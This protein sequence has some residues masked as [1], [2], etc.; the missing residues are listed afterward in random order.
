MINGSNNV[1]SDKSVTFGGQ[2][3]NILHLNG[4]FSP[5]SCVFVG[6][7]IENSTK[8]FLCLF[9]KEFVESEININLIY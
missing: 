2:V 3:D 9:M 5:K 7:K 1:I 4:Q 8:N 6:P